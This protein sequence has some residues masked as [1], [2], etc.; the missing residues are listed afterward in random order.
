M[1][2]NFKRTILDDT[3]PVTLCS[4][5][6]RDKIRR[7]AKDNKVSEATIM[8]AAVDFFL[9]SYVTQTNITE[10]KAKRKPRQKKI[11]GEQP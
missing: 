3:L 2:F 6:M 9:A 7:I 1:E 10:E 5:E 11:G 4:R 8:R